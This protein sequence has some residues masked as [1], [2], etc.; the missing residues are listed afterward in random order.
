M[1][2][3]ISN[4]AFSIYLDSVLHAAPPGPTVFNH[5][6]CTIGELENAD[7]IVF[8]FGLVGVNVSRHL[9]IYSFNI[10]PAK[11]PIA[12]GNAVTAHIHENTSARF[13]DIPKP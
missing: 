10:R 1:Q 13:F 11:K 3:S 9:A 7:G 8:T 12:K 4:S 6:N 5:T 2:I